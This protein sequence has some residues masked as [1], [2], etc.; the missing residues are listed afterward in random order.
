MMR[1]VSQLKNREKFSCCMFYYFLVI[2]SLS[3]AHV[4]QVFQALGVEVKD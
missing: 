2:A 1:V 4:N 3:K